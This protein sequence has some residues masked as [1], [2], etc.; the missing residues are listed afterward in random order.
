MKIQKLND[1]T[2]LVPKRIES[3][4]IIGDAMAEI[5]PAHDDYKKYL[6]QYQ[7]EQKLEKDEK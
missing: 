1:G 5:K 2:L 4:G 6:E 7:R 3:N